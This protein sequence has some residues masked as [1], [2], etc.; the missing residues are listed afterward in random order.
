MQF[1]QKRGQMKKVKLYQLMDLVEE[2]KK[3][4]ELI[5][6]HRKAGTSALLINQYET[7]KNQLIGSMIIELASP[8]IQSTQSYLL[9]K[10]L[11][12][13]YY[14]AKPGEA[15]INDADMSKLADAI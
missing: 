4:D 1:L 5:A 7:K 3:L 2:I 15:A 9:I 8:P 10:S 14:P 12:E 11:L 13:K 6:T